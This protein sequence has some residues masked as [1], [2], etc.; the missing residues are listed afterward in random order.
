MP[1]EERNNNGDVI[2]RIWG[3]TNTTGRRVEMLYNNG[4]SFQKTVFKDNTEETYT[5]SH[6]NDVQSD[7][8][9]SKR[10]V[11]RDENVVLSEH[12]FKKEKHN[13]NW[14]LFCSFTNDINGGMTQQQYFKKNEHGICYYD[15]DLPVK[16]DL[17]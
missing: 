17:S 14:I 16:E 1:T 12:Y 6:F 8:F 15:N 5:K 4:V 9:N 2:K 3:A 13:P 11:T 10:V 7:F